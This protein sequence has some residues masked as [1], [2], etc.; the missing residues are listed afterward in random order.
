MSFESGGIVEQNERGRDRLLR[1]E[2]E[3]HFVFHG[4]PETIQSLE[5]RQAYND[6]LETEEKEKDGAPAVFATPFVDVAIFRALVNTVDVEGDSR[7]NFGMEDGVINFAA[8]QNLLD[9]AKDKKGFVYVLK[10]EGF[11]EPIGMQCRSEE[12][13]MPVE[14]VEVSIEDLPKGIKIIET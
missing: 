3:G 1:L 12:S 10:K 9:R 5:P 4:S 7:S 14:T 6:N 11:D 13:V 8:T 2:Q